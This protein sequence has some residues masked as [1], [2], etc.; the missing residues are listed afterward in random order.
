MKNA[1]SIMLFI[2]GIAS[3]I[4]GIVTFTFNE[5]ATVMRERYGGD[6]YTGIQKAAAQTANNVSFSGSIE[7]RGFGFVLIVG[8]LAMI[9]CSLPGEKNKSKNSMSSIVPTYHYTPST[10]KGNNMKN[11]VNHAA[12]TSQPQEK[13]AEL[14]LKK[15]ELSLK[16]AAAYALKFSTDS[17]AAGYLKREMPNLSEEDRQR[18]EKALALNGEDFRNALKE[19]L[20]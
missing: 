4:L 19:M 9:A 20:N 1:R 8:G 7:K 17:G 13:K 15:A 3:I 2:V 18:L 10:A 14:T 6:A 16:E 12:E 11:D 5:G